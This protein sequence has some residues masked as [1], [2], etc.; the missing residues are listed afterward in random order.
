[1]KKIGRI[2]CIVI[3]VI[4]TISSLGACGKND[5]Y[6]VNDLVRP[7]YEDNYELMMFGDHYLDASVQSLTTYK[8]AGFNVY[9]YYPTATSVAGIVDAANL[10]EQMGLDM[11]IFGGSPL[12]WGINESVYPDAYGLFPNYFKQFDDRG[13]DFNTLTAVKGFYF[14]DEPGADLFDDMKTHYVDWMNEKYPNLI[15]HVNMFPSYATPAQL[16]IDVSALG[17][18]ETAF[19]KYIDRYAEEV[20]KHVTGSKKDIGVDHYPL[21]QRG[22]TA[23]ISETY[24][25]DLMVVSTVAH[26]YGVDFSSCI[27]AAGWGSY[28][29]P[30]NSEDIRFQVYTNLALGAKRLEFYPYNV[31]DNPDYTGM[32]KYGG[33]SV[34]YNAVKEVNFEI[35]KFDHI[36]GA[37]N[38]E[39][40]KTVTGAT[41]EDII[42]FEYVTDME[43]PALTGIKSIASSY[44]SIIGQFKDANGYQGYMLVNYTEPSKG[45][46]NVVDLEFNDA[47][48]VLMYRDGIEMVLKTDGNKISVPLEPGEGVFV[49]PLSKLAGK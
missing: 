23:F 26:Q 24:L 27:Q 16:N 47:K 38:W 39:G 1:M 45:L 25:S 6:T 10:C 21:L 20:I 36:F 3:G 19:K 49:I 17:E 31:S 22:T 33:P 11:I 28:R 29:V 14:I 5:E 44:D 13:I 48:G 12:A 34:T 42:G 32:F 35:K 41:H 37:F 7:V 4:L 30:K 40:M 46:F 18:N 2:F 9:N 8:E 43:L 15:Y